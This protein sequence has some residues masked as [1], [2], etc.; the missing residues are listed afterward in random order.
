MDTGSYF[1]ERVER[2]ERGSLDELIDARV[3]STVLYADKHSPF[4]H[5]W[6]RKNGI[7]PESVRNHEDLIS[8]PIVSG[9]TIRENQ[10]PATEDFMFRSVAWEDIFTIHETSGTSGTPKSFFLTWEDWMRYAE[11]YARSFISQGFRRGDRIIVCSSYGMN[12][13]AN[14]MTL[15]GREIKATIIPTGNCNFPQRIITS[16]RPT[17]IV[18]SVFKLLHLARRMASEGMKPGDA[19]VRRLVVGGESFSDEAR[20]YLQEI[21]QREV[22]NTYGSTEGTM[23]GECVVRQGLHVPEDLVHL[24]VYDPSL[25]RFVGDGECGRI[26]LTTLLPDSGKSGTLLINYDT[27]DTSVVLTRDTC[28]CGRTHMKILN[29]QREAETVWIHGTPVNKIDI[30]G[31]V[32]QRE[33]MDYI[34]GEYEAFVY[35][36]KEGTD[37]LEISVEAPVNLKR[38]EQEIIHENIRKF[39]FSYKPHLGLLPAETFSLR[40]TFKEPGGLELS[41]LQGRPRRIADRRGILQ[42]AG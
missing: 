5:S 40:L 37:I 7:S 41:K 19:P 6:F 9:K 34:S 13:G 20:S 32:F 16:Y 35:C 27:E 1:N 10:P 2:L 33:N 4:Y 14:T 17:G 29:P 18:G 3:R 39:L 23:C 42:K 31:G 11:K 24:D 28:S 38:G 36:T 25:Q 12:I 22:Y 30:E 21:W 26:I 15:A 8:L